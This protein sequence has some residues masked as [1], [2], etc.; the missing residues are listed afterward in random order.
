MQST[1]HGAPHLERRI[2]AFWR[3]WQQELEAMSD[4]EFGKQV[5]AHFPCA[6]VTGRCAGHEPARLTDGNLS[7]SCSEPAMSGDQRHQLVG[8]RYG[9][10]HD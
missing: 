4:E 6:A 10:G 1:E 2:E 5:I 9:S 8:W 7:I 3:T